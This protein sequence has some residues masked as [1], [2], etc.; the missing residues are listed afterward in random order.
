MAKCKCCGAE[1]PPAVVKE[2]LREALSA[3]GS[4]KT[5]KKSASSSKNFQKAIE[6]AKENYTPDRRKEAAKK[7]W[8][9]RRANAAVVK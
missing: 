3:T 5:A 7:A 6:A 4:I 9:K 2:I 8:E 1:I